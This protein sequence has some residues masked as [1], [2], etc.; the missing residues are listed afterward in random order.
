MTKKIWNLFTERFG[1]TIL[2]PQF[3]MLNFTHLAIDELKKK[4]R[5]RLVDIGCGRAPYK[6]EL[7]PFVEKYVGVDSPK[8]AD[9]Y[10]SGRKPDVL[11]DAKSLPF[12]RGEFDTAL[13]LQVLEYIDRPDQALAETQRVLKEGGALILT[14]PF[15]YPIHDYPHDRY[16]YTESALKDLLRT[17]GFN[18]IKVTSHGGFFDF[19][20]QSLNVFLFKRIQDTLDSKKTFVSFVSLFFLALSVPFTV[21]FTNILSLTFRQLSGF[22]KYP[23][24]FPLNYLVT[25]SKKG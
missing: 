1:R 25:A 11:A 15:M 12:E 22:S 24:Y 8:T 3:I 2:H 23:N 7:L 21:L 14:S 17:A 4:K 16:R 13:M 18:R 20:L 6:A 5:G 9:L 19:W 10:T